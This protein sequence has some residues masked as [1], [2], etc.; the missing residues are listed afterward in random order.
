MPLTDYKALSFDCYGTLID[1]ESGLLAALQPLLDR[2]ASP[3][4]PDEVLE[5]FGRHEVEVQSATPS[6]LYREVLATVHA[7][8]AREWNVTVSEGEN[9]L[10]A[11]SIARWPPFPDTVDALRYLRRHFRLVILSNVDR[12][13][14]SATQKLLG[15]E[16]DAVCTAQDIGS[17]KPDPRNFDFL[18]DTVRRLGIAKSQLLHV[19]QSLF[20]DHAPANRAGIDSAWIDRRHGRAGPGATRAPAGI[21]Q[22]VA[23]F[24]SLGE[25]ARAHASALVR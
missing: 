16:F 22:F 5:A 25:L 2:T 17:Y 24:T 3:R 7:R 19:A 8:L 21:P 15:I 4:T 6:L 9:R 23:R 14:F 12:Q 18:L 1:W 11:A 13:S 20:H 10:F